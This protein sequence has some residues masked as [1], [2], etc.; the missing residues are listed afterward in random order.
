MESPLR[1]PRR[2]ATPTAREHSDP[3]GH[4]RPIHWRRGLERVLKG[5]GSDGARSLTDRVRASPGLRF[6]GY[7]F[8]VVRPVGAD[9]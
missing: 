5:R 3:T 8:R 9:D 1:R 4:P 2:L 6:P 7:G